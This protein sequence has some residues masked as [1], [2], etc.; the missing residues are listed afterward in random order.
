[1]TELWIIVGATSA[2]P[3]AV[4]ALVICRSF[5]A[6]MEM[7]GDSTVAIFMVEIGDDAVVVEESNQ[8][9]FQTSTDWL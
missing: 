8:L 5:K 9:F 7:I 4:L 6:G 2:L 1:M 3:I